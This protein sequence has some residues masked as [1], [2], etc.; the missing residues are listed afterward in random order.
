MGRAPTLQDGGHGNPQGVVEAE[1]LDGE[2]APQGYLLQ[3]NDT[4]TFPEV[5]GEAGIIPVYVPA[6]GL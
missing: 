5:Y 1:R 3:Y 4:P 2:G 6:F